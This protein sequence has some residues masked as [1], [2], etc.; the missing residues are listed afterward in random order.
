MAS[1]ELAV[2]GPAPEIA[3]QDDAGTPVKLS[4][5][6]G[7]TVVLYFYPKADTPG[8]TKESCEFRDAVK[9]FGRRDAVIL[10]IS[11]D[12]PSAQAKFKTKYDLPFTL[13]ADVDHRAADAYGVWKEKSMYGKTY[14]GIERSTFVIGPDGKIR[15]IF[16]KVKPEGHAAEVLAALAG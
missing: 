9:Q 12:A 4:G 8:C 2:G 6:R 13:L 14:M 11:P 16:R 5:F 10:G 3:L 7:K 15:K 1:H